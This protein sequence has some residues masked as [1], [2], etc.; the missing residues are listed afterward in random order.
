MLRLCSLLL[1]SPLAVLGDTAVEVLTPRFRV[2]TRMPAETALQAA[3]HL[4]RAH[5]SLQALGVRPA[6]FGHE[7]IPVLLAPDRE[8]LETLFPASIAIHG[9]ARG[10][11]LTGGD[12]DYIVL[13]WDPPE[14]ARAALAHEYVHWLFRDQSRPLWH[15][16]GLAE[17]LSRSIP[18]NDG[19]S[20]GAPVPVFLQELQ[21]EEWI[22]LPRLLA[23]GQ[24]AKMVAHPAFY[25]QCWLI[26]HRH[27]TIVGAGEA[28][29]YENLE[30]QLSSE[31]LADWEA[32]LRAHFEDLLSQPPPPT[33]VGFEPLDRASFAVRPLA[34]W[35]WPVHVAD[36]WRVFSPP[37]SGS[38]KRET[39]GSV[40]TPLDQEDLTSEPRAWEMAEAEL[41]RLEDAYPER[42]EPSEILGALQMDRYDY[43]AAERT[44][45]RAVANGSS[46]PRTHHRY[47]LLLLR[48]IEGIQDAQ[49][50]RAALALQHAEKTLTRQPDEPSY[51]LTR[52]QALGLLGEWPAAADGLADLALHPEW[53]ERAD[54]EFE[55]L[56][57]RRRQ[58]AMSVPQ[59][60]IDPAEPSL[61]SGFLKTEP[62]PL[63]RPLPVVRKETWPP[64]GTVL[65]YGHIV[66]V[67]CGAGEKLVT[68]RTPRWNMRLRERADA[69]AALHY[70]PKGW[71]SLPCDA[72]GWEVN[73]AY[74]PTRDDRSVRG[75]L[76]AVV[77]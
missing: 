11:F 20:F 33:T 16:E 57:L 12:R 36:V 2:V 67:E 6:V 25:A 48:P 40:S 35:E 45:A 56:M 74:R 8:R 73:V 34:E 76:V 47:A 3:D 4:E 49:R 68:V 54:K 66:K 41:R 64:P 38:T 72:A 30:R 51:L 15:R 58:H 53:R 62:T 65:L 9:S 70:A 24:Q 18:L 69:P 7:P 63:A 59:P 61:E 1:L 14:T 19:A 46:N 50:R 42:P 39:S 10:F 13:A 21:N 28:W 43:A 71:R 60:R 5:A 44:L 23:V 26:V 55:V 22:P 31:D 17:F 32:R 52:A 27:A 37:P 77:F 29:R 75:E